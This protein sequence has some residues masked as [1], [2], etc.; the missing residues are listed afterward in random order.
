MLRAYV[1]G[2]RSGDLISQ[3]LISYAQ[4]I[5]EIYENL[6]H[7]KI[8]RYTVWH[9]RSYKSKFLCREF[10]MIPSFVCAKTCCDPTRLLV[11]YIWMRPSAIFVMEG[12][13]RYSS[14]L[15]DLSLAKTKH[16]SGGRTL[17]NLA[18]AID[19]PVFA[20]CWIVR[21]YT[22]YVLYIKILSK[23]VLLTERTHW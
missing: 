12:H 18:N 22:F 16:T 23:F 10:R 13:I 17:K 5:F 9:S 14:R 4:R 8:S 7:T 2:Q 21:R 19:Q 1:E 20:T 11:S 6:H 3:F 15:C